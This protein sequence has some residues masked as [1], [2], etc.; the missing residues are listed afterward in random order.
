MDFTANAFAQ[1][2]TSLL[3]TTSGSGSF[4]NNAVLNA[5]YTPSAQDYQAGSVILYITVYGAG[6]QTMTDNLV[7]SFMPLP[8]SATAITG[9]DWVC[10]EGYNEYTTTIL[11]NAAWYEWDLSPHAAGEITGNGNE[12]SI[13][14]AT[15][16]TGMT[17]LTVRGMNDCGGGELS[18]EFPIQV[19]DC[20]GI[21]KILAE[22]GFAV[23]PNPS[24]GVFNITFSKDASTDYHITI[25]NMTGEE[26]FESVVSGKNHE[27][28]NVSELKNGIYFMLI[29]NGV[30]RK[31]QK[32][33]IQK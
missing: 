10:M 2:F 4:N 8:E 15:G 16:W 11:A 30:T 32:L 18:Q 17:T 29:D 1:N 6:G 13:T 14:W 5:V 24:N 33:V 31:T 12:V 25:L 23:S 28:I 21:E 26:V 27:T 22:T 7:L 20:T 3:W 19:D 9:D